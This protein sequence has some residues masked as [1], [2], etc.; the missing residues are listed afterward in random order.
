MPNDAQRVLAKEIVRFE[1]PLPPTALRSN[2]RSHWRTRAAAKVHYSEEVFDRWLDV[3]REHRDAYMLECI[4][5]EKAR[6]TFTWKACHLPDQANVLP[7]CKALLDMLCTAP[8][9]P[10]KNNTIYLGLIDDDKGVEAIGKVERVR[11]RVAEGVDI[12]MERL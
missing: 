9:S 4:P 10:Q 1:C 2:N 6:V 12:I 7:N 8:K 5:W 3:E 11:S